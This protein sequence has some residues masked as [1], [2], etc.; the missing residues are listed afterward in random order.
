MSYIAV[1]GIV[2]SVGMSFLGAGQAKKQAKKQ[3]EQLWNQETMKLA[4]QEKLTLVQIATDAETKRLGFFS[5]G[6]LKYRESLQKESTVR[7]RD[8]W[9]YV[10]SLGAGTGVIYAVSLMASK[11]IKNGE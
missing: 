3:R 10:A 5:D 9:I 8:T 6:M 11:T 1:G 7:L 4:S 2:V